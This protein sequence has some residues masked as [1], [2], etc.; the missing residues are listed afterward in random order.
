[1]KA[2]RHLGIVVTDIDRS[3]NFYTNILGLKIV[4]DMNESS[5][6]LDSILGLK[7]VSVRT[8]KMKAD[9][10]NLIELLYFKSQSEKPM[11]RKITDIGCSHV[12]FTVENIDKLHEKLTREGIIFISPPKLSPDSY[13]RVAFCKDPDGTYIELVEV[14]K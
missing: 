2:I 10:D 7:G 5:D 3:I 4:K 6:Y 11:E 13:A 12:A 8:V 9:D 1:M 14:Q